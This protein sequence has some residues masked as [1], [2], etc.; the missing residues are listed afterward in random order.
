MSFVSLKQKDLEKVLGLCNQVSPKRSDIDIFTFTKIEIK[1][2]KIKFSAINPNLFYVA[3]IEAKDAEPKN[4]DISFLIKTDLFA[5]SVSL[6][7]DENIGLEIDLEK[8][9]LV[10]Q[11]SKAKHTLRIDTQNLNDFNI[12][13]E[14]PENIRA[15]VRVLTSDLIEANKAALISVGQPKSVYQ[16]EFLSVCYT[17]S[18]EEKKLTVVATD[19][20]RITKTVL[21]ANYD[22]VSEELKGQSVNYLINPKNLQ[23]LASSSEDQESIEL[24]FESD[25]LW[26][27][28]ENS[29]LIIRYGDGKYPDYDKIIPQSFSCSFLVSNKDLLASLR[30]VYLFAKTNVVNKSI[31]LKINP[32]NKKIIFSTQ[33]QD[34]YSSESS[35]EIENYEGVQEEWI[36][37]F[38]ADYLI[39]YI[40]TQT[41]EKLLWES[42]PGKPSVLSPENSKEKQ[43]YLVSGLR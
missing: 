23:L 11:G 40:N 14:I 38:N 28:L 41:S 1:D 9:T 30:Q 13:Q 2:S 42:N 12:P 26:I 37:S 29:M 22:K 32:Q 4:L 3:N 10:V 27:K 18:P 43:L 5:S 31:T 25:F 15:S 17:L 34:G 19:R 20:Y 33:T 35:L 16:P 24:S 6:I 36:Q 39:E 8:L 7:S 21:V